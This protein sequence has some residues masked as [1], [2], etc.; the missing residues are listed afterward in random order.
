[1]VMDI[2][3]RN[4]GLGAVLALS[5]PVALSKSFPFSGLRFLHLYKRK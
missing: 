3:S 4:L 5:F 2:T 1:M